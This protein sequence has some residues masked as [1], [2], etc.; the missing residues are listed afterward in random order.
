IAGVG[1]ILGAGVYALIG[2][3]AAHAGNALWM[4]FILAGVA[5]ALTAFSYARFGAMRPRN[6]PEFQ[7]TAMGFGSRIGFV[8][9]WLMVA[10]DLL[11]GWTVA[12]GFGGY[13]AHLAGTP[14]VAGGLALLVVT[15]IVMHAGVGESVAIGIVLTLIEAAGLLFIAVIGVPAWLEPNL[16]EA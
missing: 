4:A 7:Y 1:V 6:S 16:L 12:L 13:L 11:A 8:A 5:A 14:V 2:P 9:G 3:A 15:A 10:A